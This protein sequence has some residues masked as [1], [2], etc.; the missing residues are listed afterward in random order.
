M[1]VRETLL[2]FVK[3]ARTRG[4]CMVEDSFIRS[5]V[6]RSIPEKTSHTYRCQDFAPCTEC[7]KCK[8]HQ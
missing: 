6:P 3:C 4:T 7:M 5:T 2:E 1:S 8:Y